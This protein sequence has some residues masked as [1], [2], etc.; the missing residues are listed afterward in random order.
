MKSLS[1]LAMVCVVGVVAQASVVMLDD[2]SGDLSNWTGTVILEA[3]PGSNNA[4][5]WQIEDGKLQL[6]T[7][8]YNGIEQ[9][10]F[11]L[12]GASLAVGYE[13]QVDFSRANT[14]TQ[15]LGLYV[16]GAAP[17]FGVRN[18]YV[19]MYARDNGQVFSRGFDGTSE[20]GLVGDWGNIALT[21]LY[22]L[23]IDE[24]TYE[25]GYYIGEDKVAMVTRTPST[26][27]DATYIGIYA[28]VRNAG[29]LGHLDNFR[30]V[31]PEPA[32]L[33]LLGLGGLGLL[34]R[35]RA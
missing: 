5:E 35:R 3:T 19:A 22:I 4:A 20:Y 30:V 15:D 1:L 18:N 12:D 33:S 16:G 25:T 17:T 32:T 26:P 29:T 8:A 24:N 14:G 31:I 11:I 7:T 21:S 2:F 10:A 27:N 34:R 13:L 9:Y 6:V 28:D 23:R